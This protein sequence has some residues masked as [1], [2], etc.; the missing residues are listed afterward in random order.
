MSGRIAKFVGNYCE[1]LKRCGKN[2]NGIER[3]LLIKSLEDGCAEDIL[4]MVELVEQM[5]T[6]DGAK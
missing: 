5:N 1:A 3:A 2:M 6:G 4:E